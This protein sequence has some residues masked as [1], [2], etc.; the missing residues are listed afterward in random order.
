VGDSSERQADMISRQIGA[1]LSFFSGP[2]LTA[3]RPSMTCASRSG[4]NTTSL[5][6]S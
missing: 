6:A 5:R 4:R 3:F 2:G 1:T